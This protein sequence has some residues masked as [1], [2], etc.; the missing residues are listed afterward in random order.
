MKLLLHL[1]FDFG[2]L[3]MLVSSECLLPYFSLVYNILVDETVETWIAVCT[4]W[5]SYSKTSNANIP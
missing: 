3:Y 4:R 1:S 5:V 2:V